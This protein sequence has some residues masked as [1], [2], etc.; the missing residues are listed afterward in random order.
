MFAGQLRGPSSLLLLPLVCS[1]YLLM[2]HLGNENPY[3]RCVQT[4]EA[5]AS[6]M[7]FKPVLYLL[8]ASIH[9]S[10]LGCIGWTAPW[11]IQAPYLVWWLSFITPRRWICCSTC[12]LLY[13]LL[14]LPAA[15][16]GRGN[17]CW[18]ISA[19]SGRI[20]RT[21]RCQTRLLSYGHSARTSQLR[22]LQSHS[23]GL[24]WRSSMLSMK[25]LL[26]S[27]CRHLWYSL[28]LSEDC[29]TARNILLTSVFLRTLSPV[30]FLSHRLMFSRLLASLITSWFF[31]VSKTRLRF[32]FHPWLAWTLDSWVSSHIYEMRDV[33]E[34]GNWSVA[35]TYMSVRVCLLQQ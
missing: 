6:V 34:N 20:G 26:V 29:R 16:A 11:T 10:D 13:M 32:C 27:H 35:G 14:G 3:S 7:C 9:H 1:V 5:L 22:G 24:S 31:L 2:V 8:L 15:H 28:P 12:L 18:N 19:H 33:S 21:L 30:R 23:H 17:L 25:V 4:R